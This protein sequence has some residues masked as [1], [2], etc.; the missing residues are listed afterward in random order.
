V[1]F[2]SIRSIACI[3]FVAA[4]VLASLSIVVSHA[5]SV[6]NG[7]STPVSGL[8]QNLLGSSKAFWSTQP[9]PPGD[10]FLHGIGPNEN[11]PTL[12]INNTA[13]TATT[14]KFRDSSPINSSGGN[15]WQEIGSWNASPALV[16]GMLT[17]LSRLRVWVGLK[18]SNDQGTNFDI[19]AEVYKNNTLISSGMTRC[20]TG[21]TANP[22][23]AKD[24]S[25]SF[26]P[27]SQISFDGREILFVKLKTRIGTD[28]HGVPCGGRSTAAGLRVYFDS[29]T[30]ASSFG[31]TILPDT[32]PPTITA[33]VT[34]AANAS[35]WHN[36]Q[37]TVTF[38][39]ADVFTGIASC[40]APVTITTETVGQVVVGTAIDGAGNT[41]TTSVTIKFDR[42]GPNLSVT[43]PETGS[44]LFASP[45]VVGGTQQDPISGLA[46]LTC[47][48]VPALLD[49]G[50]FSCNVPLSPGSNSINAIATDIAGNTSASGLSVTYSRI[51]KITLTSP[52]NLSYLNITPTTVTGTVDDPTATVTINSVS[53]TVVNGAFSVALPLAEGPNVVTA[54][55]TSGSGGVGTASIAVTLD[56]TPPRVTITSPREGFVT[57]SDSITVAGNVN[58]IVVGTVNDEQAQVSVNGAAAEVA[59]RMFS[60]TNVPLNM[61]QN[62]IQAVGRDR[63]GNAATTQI[64][65]TRREETQPQIRLISGNNQTARIGAVVPAPLVVQLV[66]SDGNPVSDKPV[67]FKVTQDN[68]KVSTN[69]P[70]APSAIAVTN[71]QGQAQAQWTLGMRAGA[72]ANSVEAYAVGFVGTAIFTATSTLGVAGK[73]V[74]DTGNNQIGAVSQP[75]PKPLIVVVVDNG[76]NRLGGVPVTFRVKDGGGSFGGQ[77]TFTVSTDSDGRAA[78]TLTLGSQAGND[79][80]LVEADFPSN[81]LPPSSF[82]A[83]GRAAGDPTKT[84]ISGVVLDNSNV[85][86]AGVTIRAVLTNLMRSN[87]SIIQSVAAV[88]TDAQGQFNI[89]PAPVGFV[90]LLVDGSTAQRE[91]TFPTLDYD[92]VTVAGINNTLGMPIFLLPLNTNNQLCVTATTGGG[93]LTIPEAP[94]FSLT[95]G[96]GQVTFPGGSKTGCIS[97]T[98]VHGDKVPMV[99][100][101]GQQPRFIVTIQPAGAIFNP[102]A[103]ISL[104]NVDGLPPRAVTEM[105]SF[106]HDIGSFVAI[107][108]GVVSDDGQVIRSSPGVGVLKAGWHCGGDPNANG[109]V[110]DCPDCKICQGDQCVPDPGQ[111]GKTCKTEGGAS[112]ICKNGV[113]VPSVKIEA[114]FVNHDDPKNNNFAGLAEGDP[115]YAGSEES[116]SDKLKLK[117]VLEPGAP[118]VDSY[119]WSVSGP[120][121]GDYTPPAP[122][123]SAS[124]WDVGKIGSAPG[125]LTFKVVVAFSGGGQADKTRDVEVG[126]RTDDTIVVGWINPNGVTLPGGA[127]SSV[128][129]IMPAGPSTSSL[130]CN[131][132]ILDLSENFTTPNFTTLTA[133]DRSYVL[134]WMFKFGSNT[135]P[136]SVIPGGDLRDAASNS[137]DEGKV[138][139]FRDTSTNF[140]L[141]NRLQIK[142]LVNGGAFKGAPTILKQETR[143]G[144]T[145][146]PCGS[147][148]GFLGTFNGQSGPKNGPPPASPA[149]NSR[150]ALINDGSPDSGAI[151][152]FNTLTGKDLPAGSTAV[153]WESIGTKITFSVADGPRA[154]L[155]LQP[156]PTYYEYRNGL[157]VSTRPQAPSPLGNFA[158]NPYPFG[159]VSCL[160]LGGIT[161]GGRCG[162]ASAPADGSARTPPFIVP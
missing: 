78:A 23:S 57:T 148:L 100:G 16:R 62:V 72:G 88:Q 102:P 149:G 81:Q 90:K 145:K 136:S 126:V 131:L 18:T 33:T 46:S 112:G 27:F 103:A 3:V 63:V 125:T 153:F 28:T 135:D 34:P 83:S 84:T 65:V 26:T 59:N 8:A 108:T 127:S 71:A 68:G 21:V 151:R 35:G 19:Q 49:G 66:D 111:E 86:I 32:T 44:T 104:P 79:N 5:R 95:F 51:P 134:N 124:E 58:D 119:T 70:P 12:F 1:K 130:Q 45:A 80:N 53:A 9:A 11:P 157:R 155:V 74:I 36:S 47:N 91:G 6:D 116:T 69:G 96:P 50:K 117:A 139:G 94:G 98:V 67:I 120:G 4:V 97:V 76:N 154:A 138:S 160:G 118:S 122:S 143:I 128:T 60:A 30:R 77:S 73:I 162:N 89:S 2:P 39:C 142:Y 7:R 20:L 101:F 61:G 107:G 114:S 106:D 29:V 37:P 42:T 159:T 113:C 147:V 22:G 82:T 92:M 150:I 55:A 31:A 43:S 24:V 41:A 54:S 133:I 115:V 156:Y 17:E 105:Y 121:S 123:P 144:T 75:L 141:W 110:A 146:N 48:G 40:T 109:S 87:S 10:F 137:T 99:P 52:A 132:F 13:P 85:P 14:A 140:K 158:T 15:P 93:T 25:I 161:P 129:G 152:A 64:I 38:N 56:T